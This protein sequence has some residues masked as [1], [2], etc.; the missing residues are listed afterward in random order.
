M[1][2]YIQYPFAE[3]GDK[4][5]IPDLA[6]STGAVSYNQGYTQYYTLDPDTE[7][8]AKDIERT[9]MNQLFNDLS[10]NIKEW[11]EQTFPD[12]ISDDGFGNP[13]EY[14][15]DAIVNY[16]GTN[17][18]S[19]ADNND[20]IPTSSSWKVFGASNFVDLTTDQD[21]DGTKRFLNTIQGN[22]SGN[23]A[24]ATKLQT[25]RTINGVSFNGTSNI[26]LPTVNT[27][28]NQTIYDTKTFNST[29]QG[30]IT[31]ANYATNAGNASTVTNGVYTNSSQALH[32]TDALRING[33]TIYLY[34][35]NGT[36]ENVTIPTTDLSAYATT[37]YVS[38]NYVAKTSSQALHSTDALRLSGS[39]L[40][41]Y[42][43][44]GGYE[45][46][47]LSSVSN[48][49]SAHS[50]ATNGYQ[51][52]SNGLII[53]WGFLNTYQEYT[54]TITFPISFPNACLNGLA[55][56]KSYET[57]TDDSVLIRTFTTTTMQVVLKRPSENDVYWFAIGY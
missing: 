9:K 45:S 43:G 26:T 5:E 32:S 54:N 55:T 36:S 39:T 30:T 23:A 42:K 3:N 12:W 20:T 33:R 2:K 29:I 49:D 24:T 57:N 22:I 1:A 44:N 41:L 21:V 7:P 16:N 13:Y 8:L 48:F 28:G 15:K 6:T 19:L 40:Y 47:N 14:S 35:G 17:Y 50:F 25:T 34:K 53:Q 46:A 27:T 52:F 51:K 31:N 37:S 18:I 38:G 56:I 11:Q 10:S 4:E